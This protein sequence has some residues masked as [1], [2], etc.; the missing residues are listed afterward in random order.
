MEG[1]TIAPPPRDPRFIPRPS[2]LCA[3]ATDW[4]PGPVPSGW[5]AQEKIDGI[6]A[7]WIDGQLLTREG[8]PI[9][10]A[11]HVVPDLQRL[12]RRF[13]Q[14]MFFDGE[15]REDGGFHETLA[16]FNSRGQRA[17]AGT[18]FLF[19]AV[20]LEDWR[21]D[22]SEKPLTARQSEIGWALGDWA[23]KWV[24]RLP[25]RAVASSL[26]VDVLAKATWAA[27]LEGLVLKDSRA[28]YRR[29][30]SASW[31]KVKQTLTLAGLIIEVVPGT[32]A[33]RVEIASKRVKVA[34]P[35]R[36]RNLLGAEAIG[37]PCMC[38]AM[39][40]N[41]TGSA[42]RQGRLVSVGP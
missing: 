8:V 14:R 19:D 30:R 27:G 17:G 37:M 34:V 41:A 11:A 2:E 1:R 15:Y 31:L 4:K 38:E 29:Q 3:L 21:A 35:V 26:M 22:T 6:R 23:P 40:W 5:V 12:E 32:A 18:F 39:E 33:V 13:G 9:E 16:V 10:C 25:A 42:L 28:P 20:P 24:R 7:L 36:M